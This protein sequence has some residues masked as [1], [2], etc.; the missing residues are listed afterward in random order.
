MMLAC[1]QIAAATALP[2]AAGWSDERQ[3]RDLSRLMVA[4]AL[5]LGYLLFV[6][7]LIVWFGNL[8]ARV[9]FYAER[10]AGLALVPLLLGV[11][12]GWG[13]ALALLVSGRRTAAG[14]SVLAASYLIDCWW[15][16]GGPIAW[17]LA[18]LG[19]AAIAVVIRMAEARRHD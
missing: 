7:Y 1:Q 5:G 15:V 10:G 17:G 4:A 6:D 13:G 18:G 14:V 2:M 9:G 8:P 16:G 12:L 11:A 19:L 3:G